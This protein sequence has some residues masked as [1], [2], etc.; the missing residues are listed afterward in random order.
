MVASGLCTET[1]SENIVWHSLCR[2]GTFMI[3]H[4]LLLANR[5]SNLQCVFLIRIISNSYFQSKHVT[6]NQQFSLPLFKTILNAPGRSCSLVSVL[7]GAPCREVERCNINIKS[8]LKV[9]LGN[10][11]CLLFRPLLSWPIKSV[12][13]GKSFG[14]CHLVRRSNSD[15]LHWS[16]Q[17]VWNNLLL[18]SRSQDASCC[19]FPPATIGVCNNS[20]KWHQ[21][22][23][24]RLTSPTA[25]V[26][27]IRSCT[28]EC[29]GKNDEC[30]GFH[31]LGPILA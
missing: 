2:R 21:P 8:N 17:L 25:L 26:H 9:Q 18:A 16:L 30:C 1:S 22:L 12:H 3:H 27:V 5:W 28:C 15:A 4:F 11:A 23:V 24:Q 6:R 13:R 14:Q 19:V 31:L 29:C 7:C 20:R 10:F